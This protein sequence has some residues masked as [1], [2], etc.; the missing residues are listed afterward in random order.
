MSTWNQLELLSGG[1][2]TETIHILA[3]LQGEKIITNDHINAV[4]RRLLKVYAVV[5]LC[6]GKYGSAKVFKNDV[7]YFK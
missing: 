1:S 4:E 2:L 6:I 5:Q 7:E 3:S